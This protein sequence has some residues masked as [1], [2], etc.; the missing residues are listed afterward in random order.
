MQIFFSSPD[1]HNPTCCAPH[2]LAS[3]FFFSV[4][5]MP[6]V[7]I[8]TR[9]GGHTSSVLHFRQ[10]RL[11]AIL[12][13]ATGGRVCGWVGVLDVCSW[14]QGFVFFVSLAVCTGFVVV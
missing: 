3:L 7:Q 5:L 14:L 13:T 11:I 12:M 8:A 1:P 9:K 4:L 10:Q 2:S 6:R